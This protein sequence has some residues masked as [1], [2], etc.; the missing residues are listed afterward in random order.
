[1][2]FCVMLIFLK[3]DMPMAHNRLRTL[4]YNMKQ[5]QRIKTNTSETNFI[6]LILLKI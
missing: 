2:F 1:M 3:W 4:I 6:L 5:Y